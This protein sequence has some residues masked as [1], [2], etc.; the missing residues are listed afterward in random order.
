MNSALA[1]QPKLPKLI[2]QKF[3]GTSLG[4]PERILAVAQRIAQSR[5]LGRRLVVVVSA[6]GHTTDELIA[7]AHQVSP[8]PHHREMDML[9]TAGERI[10]MALL[11]MA[12][13]DLEIPAVSLTGSQTGIITDSSHRRARILRILGSRV[14]DALA[15]DRVV[16]VAGFQGVSETK[17][18]TTLGRGGSDT[19]AVAL[20]AVLDAECCEIYTDVDGVFSADPRIVPEAQLLD[21]IS[22]SMMAELAVLGA[23]VLH[24]RSVQLAKQY[25]V[26][27]RVLN[28]LSEGDPS[29][30][31]TEL[32]SEADNNGPGNGIAGGPGNGMEE[33]RVVAVTADPSKALLIIEFMRPTVAGAIW[34][35]AAE[36]HLSIVAPSLSAG[37]LQFFA[38]RDAEADWKKILVRL[39]TEGFV[40]TYE[41]QGQ[42]VPLSLVGDR[43]S[44]DGKALSAIFDALSQAGVTVTLGVASALS[45]TVAV[46]VTHVDDAVRGLHERFLQK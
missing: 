30:E 3:G 19:T 29:R 21:R 12:L 35:L 4:T 6:M 44:Q 27:V 2:V 25:R 26:K 16:I 18:I 32:I 43:F 14:R 15:Q 10:S 9:L 39:S 28:S 45:V 33:Y 38:E 23:G 40:K 7:L 37:R 46:P 17:E 8:R 34:D 11:S 36:N 22:V 31:G 41:W 13:A 24:P 1:E 42:F 5:K 20:A